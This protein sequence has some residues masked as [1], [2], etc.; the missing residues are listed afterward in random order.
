MKTL[1]LIL[2]VVTFF[3]LQMSCKKCDECEPCKHEDPEIYDGS[4]EAATPIERPEISAVACDKPFNF[5]RVGFTSTDTWTVEGNGIKQTWSAP[6]ITSNCYK[7][8]FSGYNENTSSYTIDCRTQRNKTDRAKYGDLFTFCAVTRYHNVLCPDGWRVPSGQDFID[9]DIA[10]GGTGETRGNVQDFIN[11]NYLNNYVWG[12]G[13]GG[14]CSAD[15]T[16]QNQGKVAI[17]WSQTENATDYGAALVFDIYGYV[18]EP[19]WSYEWAGLTL[20]CVK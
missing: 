20:R 4:Y 19:F 15:G 12:G 1:N 3:V 17:Y 10:M 13:Y 14:Y 9:L 11:S 16:L 2:I 8:N 5:G 18:Y 7:T 6:V